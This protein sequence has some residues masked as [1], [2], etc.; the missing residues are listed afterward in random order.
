MGKELEIGK[1]YYV[2]E[3]TNSKAIF[4]IELER[5]TPKKIYYKTIRSSADRESW[6]PQFDFNNQIFKNN[7]LGIYDNLDDCKN[8]INDTIKREIDLKL[9]QI[10]VL[11]TKKKMLNAFS[12]N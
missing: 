3:N 5:E 1:K 8:R 10:E 12:F 9:N 6:K 7:L 4:E 2:F 11:K